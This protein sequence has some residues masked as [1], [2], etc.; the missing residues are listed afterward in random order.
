MRVALSKLSGYKALS[1]LKPF[2]SILI[3]GEKRMSLLVELGRRTC[4]PAEFALVFYFHGVCFFIPNT[5]I[6][7]KSCY[8]AENWL[9]FRSS[10]IEFGQELLHYL[11]IC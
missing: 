6:V 5:R 11:R 7:A 10:T 9:Q 8:G 3:L 4:L 1:G 2:A